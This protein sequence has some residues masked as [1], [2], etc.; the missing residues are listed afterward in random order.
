MTNKHSINH[1]L[2]LKNLQISFNQKSLNFNL[3]MMEK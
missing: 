1:R 3:E 2:Y